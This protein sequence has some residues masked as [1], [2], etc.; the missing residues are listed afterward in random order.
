MLSQKT[1][2]AARDAVW[3][4]K[5]GQEKFMKVYEMCL[6]D[7]FGE[8]W[9]ANSKKHVNFEGILGELEKQLQTI[10]LDAGMTLTVFNRYRT[11]ARKHHLFGVPFKFGMNFTIGQIKEAQGL[12]KSYKDGT[13]EQKVARAFQELQ[14]QK[15]LKSAKSIVSKKGT[16]LFY[17]EKKEDTAIYF[18][19]TLG[20]VLDH[21][22][23]H[24]VAENLDKD[25]KAL[26]K[27][28]RSKIAKVS[29]YNPKEGF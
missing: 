20:K 26:L 27:L 16:V 23:N 10:C 21:F 6:K 5:E 19:S 3:T 8:D 15:N 13:E 2:K 11:A 1:E 22:E 4:V 9:K 7:F 18:N 14:S 17:P 12:V 28:I 24:T 29:K 25:Q